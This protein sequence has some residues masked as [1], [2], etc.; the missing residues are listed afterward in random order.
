MK[1]PTTWPLRLYPRNGHFARAQHVQELQKAARFLALRRMPGYPACV[2]IWQI[3]PGDHT[4]DFEL[5]VG[6]VSRLVCLR[7]HIESRLIEAE[8]LTLTFS[9]DSVEQAE[10]VVSPGLGHNVYELIGALDAGTDEIAPGFVSGRLVVSRPASSAT[11]P[12]AVTCLQYVPLPAA[13]PWGLFE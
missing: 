9:L 2:R 11:L 8:Y 3:S 4:L 1:T 10:V 6:P 13:E 5:P 7:V 12:I